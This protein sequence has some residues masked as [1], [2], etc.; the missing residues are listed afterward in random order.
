MNM[1]FE[2]LK[3]QLGITDKRAKEIKDLIDRKFNN[4]NLVISVEESYNRFFS[5]QHSVSEEI[6]IAFYWGQF[7]QALTY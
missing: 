1:A 6:L 2:H 4:T 5:V 3:K 7:D